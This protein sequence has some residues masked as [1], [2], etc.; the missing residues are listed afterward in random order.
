MKSYALTLLALVAALAGFT[1]GYTI[2]GDASELDGNCYNITP[3]FTYQ[4][5]S[6]WYND[7]IDL[8]EPFDIQFTANFD[9]S[10]SGADGMVFVFQQ[11]S[12]TVVGTDG[13]DIGFGGF[14]PS[15]GI[16]FDIYQNG[17]RSDPIFDHIAIISNGSVDHNAPTNLGGPVQASLTD[18]NIEDG[19][20]HIVQ[21]SWDPSANLLS[22]WFDCE[23][24]VEATTDLVND[25]FEGDPM[26]FWGFTGATGG[27]FA[28][29]NLCL[30]PYILGLPE[31]YTACPGDE[32]QLIFSETVIGTYS[33]EPAE[34]L[35]DPTIP[36]PIAIVNDTT[37]FVL[38]YT[39]LCG[40]TQ[41]DSTRIDVQYLDIDLGSDF[42][43][44]PGE[45]A[46]LNPG[47][48]YDFE[49]STGSEAP[50]ISVD[51]PGTYYVDATQ[52]NCYGSDTVV[53][54]LGDGVTGVEFSVVN[55]I[56]GE[57]TGQLIVE[58]V[59]GSGGDYTFDIG[60]PAQ[61]DTVFSNLAQGFYTLTVTSQDGC[62]ISENFT[63]NSD[64]LVNADFV[65]DPLEGFNPLV[66]NLTDLSTN[67]TNILYF[68]GDMTYPGNTQS[69]TFE[70]AG[71]FTIYQVAWNNSL[72]CSDTAEVVVQV[73][74]LIDLF[75][76]NILT[77]NGDGRN[78][79]LIV[80]MMGLQQLDVTI[81]DRW[82]RL[83]HEDRIQVDDLGSFEVWDPSEASDGTYYYV[84][85]G[86]SVVGDRITKE[87]HFQVLSN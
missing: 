63:V 86:S 66:V 55:T 41:I 26:V 33:W 25:V 7:Q 79:K 21:I 60:G 83:V 15:V 49:W 61:S 81:Y 44:C 38:T 85:S 36:N 39:D 47:G 34:F 8:N 17:N 50:S 77:P 87:G 14:D 22:C 58:S 67:N 2:N 29:M 3:P 46:E 74:E 12:N 51:V 19:A 31:V 78:D 16:E 71:N 40:V 37:T 70:D 59:D 27:Q 64:L 1:Q 76:P 84:I 11:V 56:C 5:G 18:P 73:S 23:L 9:D 54:S 80:L 53:V 72:A 45:S 75:I 42:S 35:D 4:S 43:L 24:R 57:E 20:D 6:I 10:E 69:I 68:V 13:G 32:V 48:D 52:G 28:E 62:F 30:D 82:G 65:A